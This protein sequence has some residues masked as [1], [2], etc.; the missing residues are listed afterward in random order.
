M[1]S[2][3]PGSLEGRYNPHL[4][5]SLL[6]L[7]FGIH[8]VDSRN[9]NSV[10]PSFFFLSFKIYSAKIVK[11]ALVTLHATPPGRWRRGR[12]LLLSQHHSGFLIQTGTW[13]NVK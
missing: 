6:C 2:Q 5:S 10:I 3:L 8:T 1:S 4:P 9:V 13:L 11:Q 12:H 7:L